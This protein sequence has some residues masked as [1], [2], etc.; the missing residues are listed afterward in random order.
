MIGYVLKDEEGKY[1]SMLGGITDDWFKASKFN[2]N[3]IESRKTYLK[4]G[5]KLHRFEVNEKGE[6]PV[7]LCGEYCNAKYLVS[8][9]KEGLSLSCERCGLDKS[10][11]GLISQRPLDY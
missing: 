6:E 11:T 1:V 8:I 4:C 7:K 3:G 9:D 5:F 10:L 2:E